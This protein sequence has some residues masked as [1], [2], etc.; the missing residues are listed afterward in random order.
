M[1]KFLDK[2]Y[3]ND[4]L[5]TFKNSFREGMKHI[6]DSVDEIQAE[7]A[8]VRRRFELATRLMGGNGTD[9]ILQNTQLVFYK[10]AFTAIVAALEARDLYTA[11]H[12]ER[13]SIMTRRF[14]DEL[15]LLPAHGVIA[16]TAAAIHDIGKVGI[17]DSTLKKPGSLSDDEW[18][19]MQRHPA[20]GADII[21]KAGKNLQF[22]ADPIRAHHEKWNGTGYPEGLK[23]EEIPYIA[24][25]IAICDSTDAMLSSRCYRRHLTED[26]CKEELMKNKGIMY[27]P[28]LVDVFIDGWDSIVGDL[29]KDVE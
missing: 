23:G 1:D 14:C 6:M 28:E 4:S 26:I 17:Q 24:R 15:N 21:L 27:Q 7:N 29:Y 10:A 16:E 25:I 18:Y 22:L 11:H 19:E 3:S 2:S 12:S 20:I 13:V 5:D 8:D 9:I